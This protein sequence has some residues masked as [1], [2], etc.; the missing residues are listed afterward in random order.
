MINR[1]CMKNCQ[2]LIFVV[3]NLGDMMILPMI[4]A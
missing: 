1:F 2:I 4:V 3:A